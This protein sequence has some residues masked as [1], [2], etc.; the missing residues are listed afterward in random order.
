MKLFELVEP[1]LELV[2][3]LEAE[4]TKNDPITA[5]ANTALKYE[6]EP[7]QV[8]EA[9]VRFTRYRLDEIMRADPI[10][11]NGYTVRG[12]DDWLVFVTDQEGNW[13]Y[14]STEM[15]PAWVEIPGPADHFSEEDTLK[16]G[17]AMLRRGITPTPASGDAEVIEDLEKHF[18]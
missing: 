16:V 7:K 11:I 2:E 1:G 8:F 18:G 4:L 9:A 12:Q 6:V 15:D 3:T 14:V 5:L 17:I 10:T 13:Y